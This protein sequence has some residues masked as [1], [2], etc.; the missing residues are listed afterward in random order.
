MKETDIMRLIQVKINEKLDCITFRNNVGLFTTKDGRKIRTGLRK[1]SSDLIGWTPI[2]I[3]K[4]MVGKT[5]AVFTAIEV[6]QNGKKPEK[7]GEQEKFIENVNRVGGIA[8]WCS[9]PEEALSKF[10]L[11]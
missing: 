1:G 11:K 8:F 3:T 4:E 7:G 2:K 9:S 5:V 6:K 10:N